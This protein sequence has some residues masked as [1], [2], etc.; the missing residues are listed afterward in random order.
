[1]LKTRLKYFK[2]CYEIIY[3]HIEN[4]FKSSYVSSTNI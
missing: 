3:A 1:M 4:S 2:M